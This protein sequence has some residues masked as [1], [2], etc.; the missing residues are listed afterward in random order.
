MLPKQ[1]DN[2][3]LV[4]I[5]RAGR[6]ERN[7]ETQQ[8]V[9]PEFFQ[10]ARMQHRGRRRRRGVCFRRPRVKWKKRNQNSEA[11]QQQQINVLLCVGADLTGAGGGLQ[12]AQS[13]NCATLAG[14]LR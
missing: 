10:H 4:P 3:Q 1:Q 7:G 5:L 13:Q 11:D 14:R 2:E 9:E 12:N 6:Q 8:S